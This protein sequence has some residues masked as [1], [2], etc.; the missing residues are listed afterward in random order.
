M[1]LLSGLRVKL[2]ADGA[3]KAEILRLSRNPL[4][5]GFTTNP[6]LM[7]KAEIRD[8]EAFCRDTLE[9]IGG[10]PIAFEVFA[11][12]FC[13]MERQ[14]HKIASW[15]A[16]VFVKIPITNSEGQSSLPLARRLSVEGVQL[17]LT[18]VF[19]LEQVRG[20]VEALSPGCSSYISVF[21]G[22]IADTGRDPIPILREAVSILAPNPRLQ[23]I[24]ASPREVLNI[25]QAD[26]IGCQ[27]ITATSDILGK[28]NN[29]GKDLNE[30]SL[31]TVRAFRSDAIAS[32][33]TL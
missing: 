16:N 24:W 18:A 29:L 17:N 3:D 11:D 26:E 14:A 7:R 31:E 9:C 10:R 1:N 21:A 6:S 5:Q 27:V 12:E 15:G 20:I 19:T 13:E 8:Y 30:F 4:I 33:F 32:G 28:L 22:R 2:F 23:L 25:F